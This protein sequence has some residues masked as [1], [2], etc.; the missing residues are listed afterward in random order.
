MLGLSWAS[1]FGCD[2]LIVDCDSA[3]LVEMVNRGLDDLHP[4]KT[5]F[6]CCKVLQNGFSRCV[7]QHVYRESNMVFEQP[8]PLISKLFLDV[9]IKR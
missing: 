6:D 1:T 2:Q 9:S 5:L 7:I 8:R 4:L 3:V